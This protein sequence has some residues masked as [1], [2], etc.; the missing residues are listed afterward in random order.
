ME[1]EIPAAILTKTLFDHHPELQ[2]RI[3]SIDLQSKEVGERI[4]ATMLPY[5]RTILT[6]L[7]K[8]S[9]KKR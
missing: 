3:R 7:Q 9:P 6:Q 2:N 1:N 8:E 5:Y 4:I